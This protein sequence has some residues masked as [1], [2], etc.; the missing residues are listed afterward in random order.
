MLFERILSILQF[1]VVVVVFIIR[2]G[3]RVRW[4]AEE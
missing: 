3:C 1:V 2:F 4:A